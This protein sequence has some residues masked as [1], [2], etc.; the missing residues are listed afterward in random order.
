MTKIWFQFLAFVLFATFTTAAFSGEKG[1]SGIDGE[2]Q[3]IL[4]NFQREKTC[5]KVFPRNL[6]IKLDKKL[7]TPN[8]ELKI[9]TE[10]DHN[11]EEF[12]YTCCTISI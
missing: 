2:E 9:K 8:W 5:P 12:F 4:E 6:C 7:D 1:G 10:E 11:K 3:I